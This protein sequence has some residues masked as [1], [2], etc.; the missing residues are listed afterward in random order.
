[1]SLINGEGAGESGGVGEANEF[2]KIAVF[3]PCLKIGTAVKGLRQRESNLSIWIQT[4]K[5]QEVRVN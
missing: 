1:M 2:Q 3:H 4:L 5:P